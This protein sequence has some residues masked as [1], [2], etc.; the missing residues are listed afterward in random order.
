[1]RLDDR[2]L[3]GANLKNVDLSR[4]TLSGAILRE[5]DL[6][7]ARLCKARLVRADLSNAMLNQADLSRAILRRANLTG[8]S[9][10]AANLGMADLRSTDLHGADLSHSDLRG[11]RLS[12]ANFSEVS[13]TRT[14]L[15]G[16][17]LN[18]SCLYHAQLSESV[19]ADVDLAGATGLES[20]HHLGPSIIDHR[21]LAQSPGIPIEFLR[22]AGLPEKII[23][24][25]QSPEY[26]SC[27]IS[28]SHVDEAF[29]HR[30]HDGLQAVGIRCWLDAHQLLPGDDL[31]SEVSRGI[32]LW[33]KVLLCCSEN[34][35]RSWWVDNEIKSTFLKE[36]E[37]TRERGRHISALIPLDID[38]HLAKWS[39]G[40]KSQLI[41]R[42]VQDFQ[43]WDQDETIFDA[44]FQRV[45]QALRSD[46]GAREAPPV[47]KL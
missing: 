29:A 31:Y 12:N 13:L 27:F 46:G 10:C 35:L 19:F 34:A 30:L 3:E 15:L 11:A 33:D 39:N 9:L 25:G 45:V 20:C 1:M 47:S 28:Y 16:A 8:T 42:V 26:Y 36:Q 7:G 40:M 4:A 14:N 43:N 32:R 18:G 44:A 41:S 17:K 37:L 23:R 5:A 22:G 2:S 6:S 24:Y 38:G 21:T